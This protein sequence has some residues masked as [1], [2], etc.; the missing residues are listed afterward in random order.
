MRLLKWI[1]WLLAA[2]I[3]VGGILAAFNWQKLVRLNAVN[4]LFAEENIV[5]N[6]SNM[7]EM[8]FSKEI[9]GAGE[10]SDWEVSEI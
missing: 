1:G 8:F 6:F 7:N 10:V 2:I 9:P 5:R 4:T 3:V